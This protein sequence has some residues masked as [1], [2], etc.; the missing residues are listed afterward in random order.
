MDT[1]TAA[2]INHQGNERASRIFPLWRF[3]PGRASFVC[4]L[5]TVVLQAL[6]ELSIQDFL[7]ISP[8]QELRIVALLVSSAP[9]V[10]LLLVVLLFSRPL[11]AYLVTNGAVLLLSLANNTKMA[12][13]TEPLT[14]RDLTTLENLEIAVQYV[15][16]GQLVVFVLLLLAIVYA[17][18]SR[19]ATA[20]RLRPSLLH[21]AGMAVLLPV[22]FYP[23]L[24]LADPSVEHTVDVILR[25][26][27]IRYG[28]ADPKLN[29]QRNGLLWHLIQTAAPY[30]TP[31]AQPERIEDFKK[32]VSA[33]RQSVSRP[34]N[35]IIIE[36]ESCWHDDT[37]FREPF[38]KLEAL[39]LAPFSAISPAYG[40]GTINAT[41]E[42]L[43]GLPAKGPLRGMIYQE[44]ADEF[45]AQALTLARQLE[46]EGYQSIA[47]H[48]Y[49]RRFWRRHVVVPKFGFRR[50]I[51]LEDMG[52]TGRQQ[53]ADDR[54]LYQSALR[55][56][57]HRPTSNFLF[58]TT[59]HTHGAYRIQDDF[60]ERDFADRLALSISRMGDFI[61]E[62]QKKYPDTLIVVI[63]DHKPP[64]SRFFY[65]QGVIPGSEFALTGEG[66]HHFHLRHEPNQDL[67]GE[68]TGYVYYADRVRQNDFCRRASGKPF[69]CVSQ[70]LDDIFIQS[71]LPAFAYGRSRGLC[72]RYHPPSYRELVREYP[73][74]LY[75]FSLFESR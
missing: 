5:A 1:K 40:A 43:A 36:C 12:L 15:S 9:A 63:P 71:S 42:L 54:C 34:S 7:I 6:I 27:S 68:V 46:A 8:F 4:I 28:P 60:G 16:D 11:T 62:V 73:D 32:L 51:A 50:F 52:D 39:G 67:L 13:T 22:V 45:S 20:D 72:D 2:K 65:E 19:R 58:L 49:K 59:V 23:F 10:L 55:E 29:V 3:P 57:E 30:P 25:S 64:L 53:W 37:H 48:P 14:W 74:W 44:Y 24:Y 70:I 35:I 75:A 31:V 38:R 66:N 61:A 26:V 69:F 17:F 21:L 56:L 18:T 47:I 33:A 41:F